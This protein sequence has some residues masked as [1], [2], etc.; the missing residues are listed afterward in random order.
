MIRINTY[1]YNDAVTGYLRYIG[2]LLKDIIREYNLKKNI[3]FEENNFILNKDNINIHTNFEHTLVKQGGRSVENGCELSEILY[4]TDKKYYIRLTNKNIWKLS[5]II[6]D[7]SIPNIINVSYSKDINVKNKQIYIPPILYEPSVD[8]GNRDLEVLTTFIN[9]QED[10]RS[11]FLNM[12]NCIGINYKNVS[13]CF[14]LNDLFSLLKNT[15]IIINIHQTNHHDTFEELR[16]LPALL[17]GV[18]VISEYSPLFE[19]IPYKDYILWSSYDNIPELLLDVTKNYDIYYDKIF[20]NTNF[21]TTINNMKEK[22]KTDLKN[23][24]LEIDNT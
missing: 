9:T 4:D 12:L 24:L 19:N 20:T 22:S 1:N 13:D 3:N 14:D 7:Y 10:R 18:I 8:K 23:K 21:N 17:C 15:K 16:C 11:R 6:I 5:D 2:N